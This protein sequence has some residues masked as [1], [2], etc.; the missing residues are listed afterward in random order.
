VLVAEIV[1]ETDL[2]APGDDASL[3]YYTV[4]RDD[5]ETVTVEAHCTGTAAAV[6]N[7]QA[8]REG[9]EYIADRGRTAA[10]R[11]AEAA[12]SPA[13]RGNTMVRLSLDALDGSV[14]ADYEYER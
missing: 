1:E 3:V 7:A 4:R 11:Y 5:G 12:Q 10:L 14:R 2:A 6:A 9:Q 8:N 13:E